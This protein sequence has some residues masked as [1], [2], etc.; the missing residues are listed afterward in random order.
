[1]SHSRGEILD[2]LYFLEN[3][4]PVNKITANGLLVWP[5]LKIELFFLLN[6][7]YSGGPKKSTNRNPNPLLVVYKGIKSAATIFIKRSKRPSV[8]YCGASHFRFS[9][10]GK[11]KSRYYNQLAKGSR[12]TGMENLFLEYENNIDNY[13][14]NLENKENTFLTYL[15]SPLLHILKKIVYQLSPPKWEGVTDLEKIF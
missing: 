2:F 14:E 1:M 3:K 7:E 6:R 15:V 10:K 4:Y 8:L 11:Y 9:E 12:D 5:I 13:S